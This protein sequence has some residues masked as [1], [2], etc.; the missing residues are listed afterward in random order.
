MVNNP[1][2]KNINVSRLHEKKPPPLEV[3]IPG[4]IKKNLFSTWYNIIL[5]I[6]SFWF[7]YFALSNVLGWVFV[8]A[9]WSVVTQNITNLLI[10]R[11]PRDQVWRIITSVLIVVCLGGFT[12]VFRKSDKKR[13]RR[14]I[15]TGWLLSM[16]IISVLLRGFS[17]DSVILP[18]VSQE[19]WSGLMLTLILSI[20]GIIASFPLA[21][22]LALGRQS[23]MPAVKITCA[24]YIETIRGVPLITILFMSQV[25]LPLFLPEEVRIETV[26]RALVGITLFSAA[27]TAEN[28]RGGL[29]SIPRGQYEAARALGLNNFLCTVFIILPQALRAVIPPIVGQFIALFKDTTLVAIVGLFDVLGIAKSITSQR[30]FIGLHMETYSFV[31]LCFFICCYAMSHASRRLEKSLGVGTR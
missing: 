27:Y 7:L 20:V 10:G 31:A 2:D 15:I 12:Y 17:A 22:L 29:A 8:D 6:L 1:A 26:T 18:M 9:K 4:W 14:S 3:G 23:N 19:L 30:E 13:L 28:I 16:P 11:Y 5:T 21:I 24:S 25:I